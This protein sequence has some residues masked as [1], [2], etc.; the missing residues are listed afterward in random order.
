MK[1]LILRGLVREQRHWHEFKSILETRLKSIDSRAEVFA[2][3]M[4]GF[5]TEVNRI[6]PKT[7]SGIVEDVR[8]RWKKLKNTDDEQWGILAVSLGGMV[9]AHWTSNYPDDF[10]KAV[11]INSSM[12]GLSPVYQRMMPQNYPKVFKLL[13]SKNL[14]QREKTILSMTTNFSS[15]MIQTRA[16]KQA[17]YGEKVNRFNALYQIMAAIRFKAPKKIVTPMLVLVGDGDRLVS[18]KCSEA[19]AQQYGAKILRHP[20]ANHDLA[21]DDPEWIATQV[22][23]WK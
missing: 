12:S 3:D 20:T 13:V 10:K 15:E 22:I 17:P 8:N 19:I 11:L 23:A 4:A 5:G 7:I 1:W 16:E 21:S 6:S 14:V 2:L 18:P 9:A